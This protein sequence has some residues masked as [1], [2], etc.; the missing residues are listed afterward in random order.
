MESPPASKKRFI[1]F[2]SLLKPVKRSKEK[3]TTAVHPQSSAAVTTRQSNMPILAYGDKKNG[4]GGQKEGLRSRQRHSQNV[5][6]SS[7]PTTMCPV[8]RAVLQDP[9]IFQVCGAPS[10]PQAMNQPKYGVYRLPR[11]S[12][13]PEKLVYLDHALASIA[14]QRVLGDVQQGARDA[15]QNGPQDTTCSSQRRSIEAKLVQRLGL[16]PFIASVPVLA[17]GSSR[18]STTKSAVANGHSFYTNNA[19]HSDDASDSGCDDFVSSDSHRSTDA[20]SDEH[21]QET[22]AT[23]INAAHDVVKSLLAR[24][25]LK[26]RHND[27]ICHDGDAEERRN[28]LASTDGRSSWMSC[29]LAQEQ[30]KPSKRNGAS[31]SSPHKRI[32]GLARGH[33][34]KANLDTSASPTRSSM[35]RYTAPAAVSTATGLSVPASPQ[36]AQRR[37]SEAARRYSLYALNSLGGHAPQREFIAQVAK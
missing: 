20:K 32:L 31:S 27:V 7:L 36:A 11:G 4:F 13:S 30:I 16:H 18:P 22:T 26:L 21:D 33:S 34:I 28:L 6:I 14:L 19:G 8:A 12:L 17:K 29:S 25:P 5:D 1:G 15:R 10:Q 37:S 2:R 3:V 35:D 23:S 24:S 9:Q